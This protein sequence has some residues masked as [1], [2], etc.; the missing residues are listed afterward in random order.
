MHTWAVVVA[1]KGT[2]IPSE[3]IGDLDRAAHPDLTFPP[4][5]HHRWSS[6]D[7]RVQ[8]AGWTHVA[9]PEIGSY[10]D[11]CGSVLTAFSGRVWK[12]Q[13]AWRRGA[14]WASQLT[15][16]VEG[17]DID[18]EAERFGGMFTLLH[19]RADGTGWITA[20]PLGTAMVYQA[21]GPTYAVITNRAALAASLATGRVRPP[22]RDLVGA[23]HFAYTGVYHDG[24]T[25]FEA[26]SVIPQATVL[27]VEAGAMPR[28]ATWSTHPWLGAEQ[29]LDLD[30]VV[31]RSVDRLRA[32]VRLLVTAG[33]VRTA[34]ELTGGK[35]SRLVLAMLLAEG[36]APE[37]EFRTWGAPTLPD[38]VVASELTERYGLDHRTSGRPLVD[39]TGLGRTGGGRRA[40]PVEHA[41]RPLDIEEQYRHHVWAS[42]GM[43]G[44]WDLHRP[45]WPPA[46]APS[47]CGI[48]VEILS[49][50]YAATD[51]LRRP[52]QLA[53]FVDR[54]GFVY[55]SAGLLSPEVSRSMRSSVTREI[56]DASPGS[57]ARDAVDGYYVRGKFRRWSGAIAE[58]DSRERIFALCD[59]TV[60]RDAFALG[61]A[62]RRSDV[63]HHRLMEAS[64]P[65]L[66]SHRFSGGGWSPELRRSHGAPVDIPLRAAGRS[67]LPTD[68]EIELHRVRRMVQRSTNGTVARA[69]RRRRPVS[70]RAAEANRMADLEAK[71]RLL[72]SLLDVPVGHAT[73]DIYDRRRTLDAVGRLG[74]LTTQGRT[75]VHLAATVATWL[76]GG[77]QKGDVY[78][79]TSAGS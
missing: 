15:D 75:E 4:S 45:L 72:R 77:E 55:D 24:R 29:D 13:A 28:A 39:R 34:C 53:R 2:A 46:A 79:D 16:L 66:A 60:I 36:I 41:T 65:G 44:L 47:L 58:L 49:T 21:D 32:A 8:A 61:A 6:D 33:E 5:A 37:V 20:D 27:H 54:G 57:D 70:G 71:T 7:G 48:G 11:D 68:V 40:G 67:W 18:T 78:V 64:A 10:W 63:L 9:A 38:V 30:E 50:N 52:Q 22:T 31:E 1:T 74:E 14:T 3:V 12:D 35:D 56:L 23:A 19:L 26:V 76:S 62:T 59:L 42:S 43:L 17:I 51:R 25:G 69:A 73:W